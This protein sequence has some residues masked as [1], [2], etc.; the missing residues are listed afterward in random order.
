MNSIP[1]NQ[2]ERDA[3]RVQAN[4]DELVERIARAI[5][6]DGVVEPFKSIRLRRSSSPNEPLHSVSAPTFNV[7]AQGSKEV[8]LGGERYRY[9]AY[10]YCIGTVEL[11]LVSQVVE[12]SRERPY[13]SISL[14]LDPALVG[15]VMMESDRKSTRL[16]SSHPLISY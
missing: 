13:L 12:A 4:R 11:P 16:N 15:S 14:E 1:P 10:H 3:Q 6:E 7:I 9:D 5:R 2:I 8:Q